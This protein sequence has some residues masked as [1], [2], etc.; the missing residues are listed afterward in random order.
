MAPFHGGDHDPSTSQASSQDANTSHKQVPSLGKPIDPKERGPINTSSQSPESHE[1]VT[2]L[3]A[4]RP[5]PI[6]L[7][8]RRQPAT[9]SGGGTQNEANRGRSARIANSGLGLQLEPPQ[10]S[11]PPQ[12]RS[13]EVD[14]L[15]EMISRMRTLSHGEV[16]IA[17]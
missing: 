17:F 7:P 9:L 6:P 16:S 2:T 3:K 12:Y 5:P 1:S 15:N 4:S 10:T 8:R 14:E 11:S 13:S